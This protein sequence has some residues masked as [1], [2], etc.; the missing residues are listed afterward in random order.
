MIN[1]ENLSITEEAKVI[2]LAKKYMALQK[3]ESIQLENLMRAD[4]CV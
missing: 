3:D 4:D 2:A 1:I